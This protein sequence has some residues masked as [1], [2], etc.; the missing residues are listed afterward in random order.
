MPDRAGEGGEN[1]RYTLEM[2]ERLVQFLTNFFANFFSVTKN[3]VALL[4]VILVL[5]AGGA[6]WYYWTHIRSVSAQ[7]AEIQY[8]T[9]EESDLYV[10]FLM[11]AYDKTSRQYWM[12]A[13]DAD[14]A[15]LFQAALASAEHLT[16]PP[17]TTTS[18]RIGTAQ[19]FAT[20]I[21]SATST[22]AKKQLTLATLNIALHNLPPVG[23]NGVLSQVQVT[24]LRQEVANVN[25]TKDLYNDLGVAKNASS[26]AVDAAYKEKVATLA[27]GTTTAAK[28]ELQK[29]TY[30]HKVLAD[31]ATKSLYDE[32]QVEPTVF[33]QVIGHTL[34]ADISQISPTTLQEFGHAVDSVNGTAGIDSLVIDLRGNIGGALDFAPAFL[35]LFVGQNQYAF[36]LFH[37]GKYDP[38]RTTVGKYPGVERFKEIGLITDNMTQSTAEVT[39]A[40]FKRFHLGV[41]VGGTTRGWGTVENTT[42]IE[43]VID[44]NEKYALLLVHYL[45]LRDDGQPVQDKGVEPD[46]FTSDANWRSELPAH[47]RS[48]SIVSALSKEATQAP[49][50]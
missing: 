11:E 36:D 40:M 32:S 23:R 19:M 39:T 4:S 16:V 24:Q 43:T 26:T 9:P 38:Q 49:L 1:L 27:N 47:F 34:Y 17:A 45:T 29:V 15:I 41:V 6:G 48:A 12:K 20:A 13:K 31:A 18:D 33:Y 21:A 2:E 3:R 44:P 35:G 22:D 25:P 37:Q 14:Y 28:V 7:V 5:V 30:A 46:I 10:R 42:P 50:R 8:Q